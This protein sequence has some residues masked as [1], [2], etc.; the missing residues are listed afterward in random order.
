MTWAK[1]REKRDAFAEQAG[2]LLSLKQQ[3]DRGDIAEADAHLSRR[4]LHLSNLLH[5]D[6]AIRQSSPRAVAMADKIDSYFGAESGTNKQ[7][8][9]NAST[10]TNQAALRTD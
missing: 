2:D 9:T 8:R 5:R 10:T 6:S 1:N 4:L 7:G 3:L